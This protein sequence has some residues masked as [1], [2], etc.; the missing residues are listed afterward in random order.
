MTIS[1]WIIF[2]IILA[3]GLWFYYKKKKIIIHKPDRPKEKSNK[4]YSFSNIDK[5]LENITATEISNE[6]KNEIESDLENEDDMEK[7]HTKK[8]FDVKKGVIDSIFLERKKK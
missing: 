3:I 2:S 8:P 6:E 4:K 1:I 5:M 7:D